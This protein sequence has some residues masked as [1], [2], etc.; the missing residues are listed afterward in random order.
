MA[1]T[2]QH[3][4]SRLD[5]YYSDLEARAAK[6][7]LA[8]LSRSEE[9]VRGETLFQIY[10]KTGQLEPG[11]EHSEGFLQLMNKLENDFYITA[12]DGGFAFFSRVLRLWWKAH[13]G[14]QG[15]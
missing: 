2:F 15:L 10:C 13:F 7:I 8:T 6:S 1:V 14:F 5:E 12:R 3:Y 11:G 4:R 9:A